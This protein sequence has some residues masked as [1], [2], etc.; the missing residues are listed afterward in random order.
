MAPA[1]PKGARIVGPWARLKLA[2]VLTL[3]AAYDARRLWKHSYLTG[4]KGRETLRSRMHMTGHF[5]E[6]GLSMRSPRAGF[7]KDRVALLCDDLG[8]Y[9]RHYGWDATCEIMLRTLEAYRDFNA[10]AGQDIAALDQELGQIAALRDWQGAPLRGGTETVT[11]EEIQRRGKID[12][13]DFAEARHSI[14]R[15]APG[16][17]AP[18]KIDRAVRAAQMTPSSCNRQTC[19][20]WIWTEP[21][22]VQRVLAMQSG[23]RNFGH[24]V[25]GVAIV[26][27]DL[28]HWYEVE[29]RYQGWVD[30]G[31]FA[32]SLA[33][34]LHAEGL[35][36]V[37]LNW[38]EEYPQDQALRELTGIPESALV[39]VMIGFGNLP[40]TLTVPVSQR[41]PLDTCLT[42]NLPLK[43]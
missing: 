26:A 8:S 10:G 18:D 40:E 29:E 14:R 32:M 1:Q 43:G 34:G 7:G 27:S 17:V 22:A 15:F 28:T 42:M 9:A 31:M 16:P 5:L 25:S 11:R 30:A 2:W 23:N 12:F 21:E 33:L 38:G 24:E 35:G 41:G 20:V 13:L 37:M 39:A 3:N 36:A 19:R 6:Y 4:I